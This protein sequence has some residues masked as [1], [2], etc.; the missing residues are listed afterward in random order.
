MSRDV[1]AEA[2]KAT[3]KGLAALVHYSTRVIKSDQLA[4]SFHAYHLHLSIFLEDDSQEVVLPNASSFATITI[5][6]A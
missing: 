5:V 6:I 3:S 4:K 2:I 1:T